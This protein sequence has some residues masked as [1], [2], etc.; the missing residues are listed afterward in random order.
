[1]DSAMPGVW[2]ELGVCRKMVFSRRMFQP[3]LTPRGRAKRSSS[4]AGPLLNVRY[5]VVS[6]Q[7][8][9]RS[10]FVPP[11]SDFGWNAEGQLLRRRVLEEDDRCFFT[12]SLLLHRCTDDGFDVNQGTIHDREV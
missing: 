2:D 9:S 8:A 10:V 7:T 6:G 11:M 1:L 3:F 4:L 5:W 12:S